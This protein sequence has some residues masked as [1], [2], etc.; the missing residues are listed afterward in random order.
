[1]RRTTIAIAAGLALSLTSGLSAA[2]ATSTVSAPADATSATASPAGWPQWC[3]F[4]NKVGDR[5]RCGYSSE[6]DC[7]RALGEPDA[8]CILDPYLT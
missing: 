3:G 5:V 7:K 8:I 4:H 6:S 1:M 2:A